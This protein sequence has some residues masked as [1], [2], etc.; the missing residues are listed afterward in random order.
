MFSLSG[1]SAIPG[2][3]LSALSD[4][5]QHLALHTT[6]VFIAASLATLCDDS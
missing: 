1:G 6:T 4:A 2:Q 3:P 5:E